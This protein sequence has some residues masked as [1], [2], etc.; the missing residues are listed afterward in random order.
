MNQYDG[1]FLIGFGGPTPGCCKRLDPCPG[2]EALCFVQCIVGT[3]NMDRVEEVAKHYN[4][5]G[6]FSPFNELTF[7]QATA[8]KN[9]LKSRGLDLP[10]YIGMRNWSPFFGETVEQ[11]VT[12]GSR[13]IIGIILS[14]FQSSAS[15]ERYQQEVQDAVNMSENGPLV[16]RYIEPWYK[17]DGF[18]DA[19]TD[20]IRSSCLGW[21]RERFKRA[22]LILTAHAIPQTA[23]EQSPYTKQFIETAKLVATRLDKHF[24]IAYQS[25]P[26][27]PPISWTQPT[28]ESLIESK[29]GKN[30]ND[31]IVSPI[32]FLC[33]H[34]EILYDLDIAG[35]KKAQSCG[36]TMV[37]AGTVGNHPLFIEMLA[38]RIEDMLSDSKK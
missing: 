9:V 12:D 11:M 35:K 32:G 20:L 1:V 29:K 10:V 13:S 19:V 5:F 8:L 34:V 6:G 7:K 22:G 38:D 18:I 17:E 28:I 21:S 37:R 23:A 2:S 26:D 15:W 33:D 31:I 4:V 27:N 14:S 30:V 36:I 3:N 24:E 16:V 25:A